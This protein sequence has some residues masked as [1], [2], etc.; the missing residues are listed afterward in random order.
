MNNW[1]HSRCLNTTSSPCANSMA[2]PEAYCSPNQNQIELIQQPEYWYQQ[3]QRGIS[4][5]SSGLSR[6]E[7]YSPCST[8][9]LNLD[10][11]HAM[12]PP[13]SSSCSSQFMP[14]IDPMV[15]SNNSSH[16]TALAPTSQPPSAY[17]QPMMMPLLEHETQAHHDKLLSHYNSHASMMS[18]THMNTYDLRSPTSPIISNMYSMNAAPS[19]M[20]ASNMY[21]S[22][23]NNYTHHQQPIYTHHHAI[24]HSL[25]TPSLQHAY[26]QPPVYNSYPGNVKYAQQQQAGHLMTTTEA[27]E[28]NA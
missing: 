5:A 12:N 23:H 22:Y 25:P 9:M 28:G 20:P 3:Q 17:Q 18:T 13:L 10:D 15:Y 6:E 24:P 16:A 1:E 4:P 27:K 26:G 8:P 11:T 2:T 19:G 14:L 7:S 21:V